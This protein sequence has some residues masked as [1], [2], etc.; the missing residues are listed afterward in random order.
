MSLVFAAVGL[1][2]SGT[3]PPTMTCSSANCGGCCDQTTNKCV[4]GVEL[5]ACGRGG[6]ACVSC[7]INFQCVVGSCTAPNAT[8]GGSAVGGGFVTGGGAS[9]GGAAGGGS[10]GGGAA[11]G[12]AAG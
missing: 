5:S 10:S 1:S 4:A 7:P 8:G 11:G 9:G 12:G 6:Q 3:P 2:C